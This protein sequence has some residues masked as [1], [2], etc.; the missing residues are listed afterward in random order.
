MADTMMTRDEIQN[1]LGQLALRENSMREE[2]GLMANHVKRQE[3]EIRTLD[4]RENSHYQEFKQFEQLS[5]DRER[6]EAEEVRD[7]DVQ[8]SNRVHFLLE[9]KGRLDLFGGFTKKCRIDAKKHSYYRGVSGVDTKKM[10]FKALSDYIG[11]WEP[12]GWGTS[13]YIEHLDRLKRYETP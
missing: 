4:D 12:K 13:L 3:A 1:A 5:K 11:T 9:P 6:I 10:Y 8:I 2:F 7:L